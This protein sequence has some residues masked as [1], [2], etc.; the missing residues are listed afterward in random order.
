[1]IFHDGTGNMSM[2]GKVLR[3]VDFSHSSDTTFLCSFLVKW[4]TAE[5]KQP[6]DLFKGRGS[7]QKQIFSLTICSLHFLQSP[8]SLVTVPSFWFSTSPPLFLSHFPF[9]LRFF[10]C[11]FMCCLFFSLAFLCI[12]YSF[13]IFVLLSP[14]FTYILSQDHS[15]NESLFSSFCST[16]LVLHTILKFWFRQN[17]HWS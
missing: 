12:I 13:H 4:M 6:G 14:K 9:L 7:E 17:S 2:S 11:F 16:L 10:S 3:K 5:I 1:M 8:V 15:N